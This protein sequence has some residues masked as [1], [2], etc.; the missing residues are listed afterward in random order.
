M[1]Y[2]GIAIMVCAGLGLA[3][4][5]YQ[6][7]YMVIEDYHD[8]LWADPLAPACSRTERRHLRKRCSECSMIAELATT[9]LVTRS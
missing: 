6:L 2:N 8:R 9:R 1:I 3:G 4:V 5:L 7:H